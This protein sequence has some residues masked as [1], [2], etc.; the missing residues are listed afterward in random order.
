MNLMKKWKKRGDRVRPWQG[1]GSYKKVTPDSQLENSRPPEI[2]PLAQGHSLLSSTQGAAVP[3]HHD[4]GTQVQPCRESP[5]SQQFW[6]CCWQLCDWG[7]KTAEPSQHPRLQRMDWADPSHHSRAF[8]HWSPKIVMLKYS[9]SSAIN[10]LW[11]F[12]WRGHCFMF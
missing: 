8:W 2:S 9:K 5:G 11:R 4:P 6:A 3:G 7:H 10:C 1:A 12:Y